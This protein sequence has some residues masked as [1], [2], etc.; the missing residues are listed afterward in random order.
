MVEDLK[1]MEA[2]LLTLKRQV[3]K[4]TVLGLSWDTAV[5]LLL[6]AGLTEVSSQL[7]TLSKALLANARN[8][9][10][11]AIAPSRAPK[12]GRGRPKRQGDPVL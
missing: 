7:D 9:V 1:H 6:I 8:P 3:E 4:V 2:S 12:R 11:D 10:V 5:Q